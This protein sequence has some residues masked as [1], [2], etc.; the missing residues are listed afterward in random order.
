MRRRARRR[1]LGL[2]SPREVSLDRWLLGEAV[3]RL[4][5]DVTGLPRPQVGEPLYA[6]CHARL[7]STQ[8]AAQNQA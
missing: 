7:V 8:C 1:F 4:F 5:E 2:F 3:H 6:S